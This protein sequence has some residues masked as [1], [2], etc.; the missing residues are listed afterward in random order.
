M[1]RFQY[2]IDKI[3]TAPLTSEPFGHI[4]IEDLFAGEDFAAIIGSPEIAIPVATDDDDLFAK[5]DSAGYKVI[6]FPGCIIDQQAYRDWHRAKQSGDDNIHSACEGF[7]MTLRLVQPQ[8]E[9]LAE[10]SAFFSGAAFNQAVADRFGVD[11]STCTVDGG[12]QKY[13]D[14]YEISPHSDIRRKAATFMVNINPHAHAAQ[15]DHHTHYMRLKPDY[16]Y[17][18][19]FWDQRDDVDRCW[20]PWDWCETVKSQPV[21]NSIVLFAPANDTMHAVKVDYDHLAGQ[22]TQL[23]GNIWY[24]SS[25]ALKRVEWE[26]LTGGSIEAIRIPEEKRSIKDLVPAG[27]RQVL[28]SVIK[29]QPDSPPEPEAS[30][31]SPNYYQRDF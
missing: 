24:P 20:V 14:G 29:G 31:V 16:R 12:I 18:R 25:Q 26:D 28:R 3:T 27:V 6:D 19:E 4:Y 9:F 7:G 17:V 1:S 5:L 2:I 8:S 21:N 22:R 30:T 23:Y 10:L 15:A 13:L 11:L